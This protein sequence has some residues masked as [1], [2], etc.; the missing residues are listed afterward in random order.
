M[1]AVSI[2][3]GGMA[4][5]SRTHFGGAL[6][7]AEAAHWVEWGG[8]LEEHWVHGVSEANGEWESDRNGTCQHQAS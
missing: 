1:I 8:S 2:L 6:G 4:P 7:P 5:W 3:E